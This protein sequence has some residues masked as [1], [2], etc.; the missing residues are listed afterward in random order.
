MNIMLTV[1]DYTPAPFWFLNHQLEKDELLRQLRLMK[2]QG[3]NA[4]FMHP[5]AG[6]RIPYGSNEWFELIRYIAEEA[7]KLGMKPWL[8]DEDPFPSGPAGGRIFLEHPEYRARELVFREILPENGQASA[9]LGEGKL[10]ELLAVRTDADGNVLESRDVSGDAG[11]LRDDFFRTLWP[12]PYYYHLFGRKTYHHYRAET[13]YPHYQIRIPLADGWKIYAVTAETVTANKYGGIPD[14][15]NPECVREFM[16]WTHEQ[17][18]AKLGDLFG[19][20]I[21]GI[22]TDE[23]ACGGTY[24]WT[25][26][27][28][29]EFRKR[30]GMEFQGHCHLIFRGNTA[31]AEKFREAYWQTVYEL[32]TEAFF[33][34][35]NEWCRENHL[36]L[37]G[38]GIGEEMPLAT[39][40]GMNIFG[41]QKYT[42]IPGFDHITPNIPNWSDFTSLNLGGK[43]VASAAEQNGMNRVMCE[44]FGC[45]PY[46]FN[47]DGMKRNMRWLYA[48][49]VNMPV[50][51]GF[52]YSYDGFRK[53]DAGKSFFFQSPDY[54]RF[55]EFAA[56]AG[57]LGWKLGESRSCVQLCLLYP[58]NT[59]RRL[60]PAEQPRA[61][62]YM[63]QLYRTVQILLRNQIPFELADEETLRL[64][65]IREDGFR[66]GRKI[67]QK[68][69]LPFP[70][71]REWLNRYQPFFTGLDAAVHMENDFA[72]LEDST[73]KKAG[74]VMIQY[75][76]HENG[77]L[78]YI[79]HNSPD[80]ARFRLNIRHLSGGLYRYGEDMESLFRFSPD[81]SFELPAYGAALFELPDSPL[82]EKDYPEQILPDPDL[83]FLV[84]PV[85]DYVPDI[86]G[87]A[88]AVGDW[89][90]SAG[91]EYYPNVHYNLIREIAGSERPH[92]KRIGSKPIF[93]CAPERRTFY[94]VRVVYESSFN[95]PEV[96]GLWQLLFEHDTFQGKAEL[97]LNGE[98]LSAAER[99]R[100]YDS[101]NM[102]VDLSGKL[103]A[104]KNTL[105]AVFPS[106][107][108]FDGITSM[109]Y[110]RKR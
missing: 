24:A 1:E 25:P 76:I 27:F 57:R 17:Y 85:W 87:I 78:L 103:R 80:R 23:T 6:L 83:D 43:L 70:V 48:L 66:C 35:V 90:V 95:L 99:C 31:E 106:A 22:F 39:T 28:A 5:R 65:E 15:L 13:F 29:E 30:R 8:Y 92:P 98:K 45:N 102:A 10:L 54:D 42:G 88:A 11:M 63:E 71:E 104:G 94:P 72:V 26:R 18:K 58:E 107:E 105:Q 110:I 47:Q 68:L 59:F 101:W 41:L 81:R 20:V 2:E 93:D 56:Y 64:A 40:N 19:S 51:H 37:C 49:G 34:P 61:V 89:D 91:N 38:H 100:V 53:D 50:P 108:E 82:N 9:D 12:S 97:F 62:E 52:H 60:V 33:M 86:P 14:N 74:T 109:V 69:L 73:G 55:H 84:H 36:L 21:P 67:Y 7:A 32:F 44:C 75:R 79:F 46:N 3:I 4:F 96:S 77:R 16:H